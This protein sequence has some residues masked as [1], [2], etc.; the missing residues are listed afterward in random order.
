M[1]VSLPVKGNIQNLWIMRLFF[2]GKQ[3]GKTLTYFADPR[4]IPDVPISSIPP[5]LSRLRPLMSLL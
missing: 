4:N 3:E 5:S 2:C 1:A